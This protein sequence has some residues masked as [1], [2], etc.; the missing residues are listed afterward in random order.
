M[1][2]MSRFGKCS[3]PPLAQ[4][5]AARSSSELV[6]NLHTSYKQITLTAHD[7]YKNHM[8][9]HVSNDLQQIP[10]MA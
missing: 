6:E 5:N 8:Y 9:V 7:N 10:F 2:D 1:L 4:I 3:I